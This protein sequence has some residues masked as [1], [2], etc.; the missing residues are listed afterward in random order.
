MDPPDSIL[1]EAQRFFCEEDA[2]WGE[3]PG[4]SVV[5]RS[6]RILV[7]EDSE[8]TRESLRL[9]LEEWSCVVDTAI[10]GADG[11]RLALHGHYDA[12]ILDLKIPHIDGFEAG[13]VI[14]LKNPRPYICAF[15]AY[16]SARDRGQTKMAGFDKHIAKGSPTSITEL[17]ATISQLKSLL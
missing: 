6:L 14:A 9:M 3:K 8:D 13:R 7:V 11:L 12:I 16:A 2:R 15:S 10:D 4:R 1:V 5:P 17:E